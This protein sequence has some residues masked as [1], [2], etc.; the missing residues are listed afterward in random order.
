MPRL[1]LCPCDSFYSSLQVSLQFTL[2]LL[3]SEAI[4][5]AAPMVEFDEVRTLDIT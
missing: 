2:M 1:H 3:P 5:S 4:M